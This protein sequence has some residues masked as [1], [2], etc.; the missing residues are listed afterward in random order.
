[1]QDFGAD[2][3]QFDLDR[4]IG[5][6]DSTERLRKIDESQKGSLVVVQFE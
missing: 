2:R 4:D 6:R 1:L 5:A 3:I